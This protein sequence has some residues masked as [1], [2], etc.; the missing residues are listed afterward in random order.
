MGTC[1]LSVFINRPQQDVFDLL[2]D[3]AD[4]SEWDSDIES[5]A[6]TSSD[7][8]GIGLIYRA[9]GEKLGSDKE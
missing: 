3:P 8:H 4:L 2:S 5:T 6:C 9:S 1:T 7:A